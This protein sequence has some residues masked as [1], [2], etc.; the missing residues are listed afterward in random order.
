MAAPPAQVP[1]VKTVRVPKPMQ[2]PS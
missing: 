1:S 2:L